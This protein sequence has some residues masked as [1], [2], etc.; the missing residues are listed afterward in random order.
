MG[1]GRTSGRWRTFPLRPTIVVL[2]DIHR[3]FAASAEFR[4]LE[5]QAT[6]VIYTDRAAT[7]EELARRLAPADIAVLIRRRST[8]DGDLLRRLHRLRAIVQAGGFYPHLDLVTATELGI[9]VL[10]APGIAS[11]AVAELEFGLIL[12]LWR[13]I[14]ELTKHVRAGHWHGW[15][16]REL[17]GKTLGTIGLGA[18]GRCVANIATGFGMRVLAYSRSLTAER[19]R[20]VRAEAVALDDALRLS[21]VL[22]IHV[23]LTDET[24]GLI[25]AREL[26]L[27]KREAIIVNTSR[28]AILDEDAL[29]EALRDGKI[30]GAGLDVLTDEPPRPDN[31]LLSMSNV[32]ITPHIG[33]Q[34]WEVYGCF[35]AVST[36]NI[37]SL[38]AG[39]PENVVDP[40][41]LAVRRLGQ[42]SCAPYPELCR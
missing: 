7:R 10:G 29:A 20:E 26:A 6:I 5:R 12:A 2:D 23:N 38:F 37:R 3:V 30:A 15:V 39:R 9:P 21:D 40:E 19:A 41:A 14:P 42:A 13:N 33:W 24:R 17:H 36:R 25:G 34:T 31:P 22:T 32:L 28:G 4:A 35:V 11:Q 8:L 18:I 16:G 27:M 1:Q